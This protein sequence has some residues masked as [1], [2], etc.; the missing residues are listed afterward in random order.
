MSD[1]I[2]QEKTEVVNQ[3]NNA[4][5]NPELLLMTAVEK[6][7]SIETIKELML[8]RTQL[9]NEW[10]KEQY[11]KC[12]SLFQ[13]MCPVIEKTKKVYD[14]DKNTKLRK[15]DNN[16]REIIRWSFAP[17]DSI[18]MQI[19]NILKEFGF[20]YDIKTR[21]TEK[22]ITAICISHH[23]YGHSEETEFTIPIDKTAYMLDSQ[24]IASALTY[25]KRYAFCNAFGIMTGDEDDDA[26]N[27]D[28]DSNK[29][30]NLNIIKNEIKGNKPDFINPD[31]KPNANVISQKFGNIPAETKRV[32]VIKES[33]K[34]LSPLNK[35]DLV[36][37]KT[38]FQYYI[39]MRKTIS[40]LTD[41]EYETELNNLMILEN[42]I[43]Q[44]HTGAVNNDGPVDVEFHLDQVDNTTL[45]KGVL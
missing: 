43:K 24:K 23:K 44:L 6:E 25:A 39:D 22:D 18:I 41:I 16:G 12:L 19:K 1:I 32:K 20:S 9:K 3:N 29:N 2:K 21:Q 8:L 30:N 34:L 5:V 17:L 10:A 14:I 38:E 37:F 13:E 15:L 31:K 26:N 27:T 33:I 4:M 35:L 7:L 45:P 36:H 40:E 11:Y 28:F 42:K